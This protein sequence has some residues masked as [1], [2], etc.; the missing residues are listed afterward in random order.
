MEAD[1]QRIKNCYYPLKPIDQV[2]I[3]P[4]FYGLLQVMGDATGVDKS[5]VS[6]TV[7]NN[8]DTIL[9]TISVLTHGKLHYG[10]LIVD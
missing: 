5:T 4:Q 3:A 7:H 10:I 6:L 8:A 2:L 9:E 1:L